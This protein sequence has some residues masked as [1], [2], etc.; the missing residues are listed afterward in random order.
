MSQPKRDRRD[1]EE[2]PALIDTLA[3]GDVSQAW[4]S[5]HALIAIS[6][7]RHARRLLQIAAHGKSVHARQAAIYAIW[8]L[9]EER[10][11][12]ILI[13]IGADIENES[14]QTRSMAVEALGNTVFR[15]RRKQEALARHLFDPSE[16]VK[17]SALCALSF[18]QSIPPFIQTAL[19]EKLTDPGRLDDERVIARMANEILNRSS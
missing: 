19:R 10:G 6:S 9:G 11:A 2:I 15:R 3:K 14:E 1:W 18:L 17:Y 13:R 16:D 5:A 8:L 4:A 12:E 7:R